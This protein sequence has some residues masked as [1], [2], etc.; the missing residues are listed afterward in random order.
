LELNHFDGY[1]KIKTLMVQD[2]RNEV[3]ALYEQHAS[4]L[5]RYARGKTG[6]SEIA[7][8]GLQEAFLRYYV[9]RM[10]G[11]EILSPR[12]WL[13]EVLRNY[14]F[15]RSRASSV[16]RE[17]AGE[18]MEH[19][20]DDRQDPEGRVERLQMAREIAASLTGR[21]L[22]CLRLR[23]EGLSY[24]EIRAAMQVRSGT[25]GALLAR[26]HEKI[27]KQAANECG[28]EPALAGA[29]F[30]LVYDREPAGART[31]AVGTRREWY[32]G[33]RAV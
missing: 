11:R 22:E 32:G 23:T 27:R 12:A 33:T 17:V 13:Y 15:D 19:V 6:S 3:A 25:V 20:P 28:A 24:E 1:R 2:V 29:V 4:S 18:H 8:E 26:A 5:L 31:E 21:E 16:S 7:Q 10:C 14:V 30:C 9:A